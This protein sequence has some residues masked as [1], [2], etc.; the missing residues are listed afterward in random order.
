MRKKTA[1]PKKNA[2]FLYRRDPGGIFQGFVVQMDTKDL[3]NLSDEELLARIEKGDDAALNALIEKYERLLRTIIHYEIRN[4]QEEA[5]IYAET[6]FAIVRRLRR[7]TDN[8]R[9]VKQWLKQVARSKCKAFLVNAKKRSIIR[10]YA[11]EDYEFTVD[12]EERKP[13]HRLYTDER[14]EAIFEVVE[15]MGAVYVETVDLWAKGLTETE[16]AVELDIPKG[17]VKSRRAKIREKC[18]ERL[19]VSSL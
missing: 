6:R 2:I 3:T 17:T 19:G 10:E 15:E 11:Q 9:D 18:R 13:L 7:S 1:I 8:I 12:A 5:D 14:V 16:S 4:S